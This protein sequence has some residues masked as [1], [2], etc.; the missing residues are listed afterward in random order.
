MRRIFGEDVFIAPRLMEEM[1]EWVIDDLNTIEFMTAGLVAVA[2]DMPMLVHE[3]TMS[4]DSLSAMKDCGLSIGENVITYR[5]R[6]DYI[7]QVTA[8]AASGLKPVFQHANPPGLFEDCDPAIRD[9]TIRFLNDKSNLGELAGPHNAPARRILDPF[10][11]AAALGLKTPTV[12]KVATDKPNGG[13]TDVAICRKKR[14]LPRAYKKFSSADRVIVEDYI[15]A[16]AN[17]SVRYEIL[18]AEPPR[19]SGHST[20]ICMRNGVHVG[21][22]VRAEDA[23]PATVLDL[24]RTIAEAGRERGYFG[25]AGFDILVDRNSRAWAI[26]LNFRM[27]SSSAFGY[28]FDALAE[29]RAMTCGRLAFCFI[30]HGLSSFL[31]RCRPA[32]EAGW[33]VPVSTFD[34]EFGVADPGQAR[35]RMMIMGRDEDDLV[36]NERRLE[37]LGAELHPLRKPPFWRA[38]LP[39]SLF[40][41]ASF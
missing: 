9:E 10:D 25:L 4:P 34:P 20:Q 40:G 12:L 18:R 19:S 37:A 26:D 16:S 36:R 32:F 2:G 33:L 17:W 41:A 8:M 14:H 35:C 30:D 24:A 39:S 3:S 15:Q 31:V 6:Q 38:F 28:L 11:E 23:P 22:L 5:D 1:S 7:G 29:P 13:A 27:T 21:N